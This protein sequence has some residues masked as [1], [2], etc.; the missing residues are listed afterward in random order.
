M[1]SLTRSTSLSARNQKN[2]SSAPEA[3]TSSQVSTASALLYLKTGMADAETAS[4]NRKK[5]SGLSRKF[6]PRLPSINL[7]MKTLVI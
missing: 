7:E 4:N 5:A 1:A 2:T 6:L 3:R